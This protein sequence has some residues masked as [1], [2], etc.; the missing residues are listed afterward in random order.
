MHFYL[1]NHE[2]TFEDLK[3][4]LDYCGHDVEFINI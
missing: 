4:F 3:K 2:A 1:L